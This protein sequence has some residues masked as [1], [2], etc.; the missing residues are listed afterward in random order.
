MPAKR[1]YVVK[2]GSQVEGISEDLIQ[3]ILSLP[4]VRTVEQG[5]TTFY[6]VGSYDAIPEALRRELELRGMGLQAVVMAEENGKLIDVSSRS[7]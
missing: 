2:V 6:V 5:D 4:D 3:K 1:V 7:R